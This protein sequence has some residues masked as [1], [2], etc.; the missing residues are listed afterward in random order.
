MNLEKISD[1]GKFP[2]DKKPVTKKEIEPGKFRK[3][4]EEVEQVNP[5][6]R[7]KRKLG[8]ESDAS[9]SS[10]ITSPASKPITQNTPSA[11]PP[12]DFYEE[13]SSVSESSSTEKTNKTSKKKDKTDKTK[14][15]LPAKELEQQEEDIEPISLSAVRK[16]SSSQPK[17]KAPSHNLENIPELSTEKKEALKRAHI[18]KDHRLAEKKAATEK[19]LQSEKNDSLPQEPAP[20]TKKP[21]TPSKTLA[22]S[23]QKFHPKKE[24]TQK[25][26]PP[27]KKHE[28]EAEELEIVLPTTHRTEAPAVAPTEALPPTLQNEEAARLFAHM[29]SQITAVVKKGET[30]TTITLTGEAFKN[31]V[32]FGSQIVIK[33]SPDLAARSYNI[34][35]F[36]ATSEAKTLFDKYAPTL[37]E[38]FQNKQ[39][40]FSIHRVES[41]HRSKLLIKRKPK[42]GDEESPGE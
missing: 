13:E 12:R 21:K 20:T 3:F 36:G 5:D 27:E 38:T 35:L 11:P 37:L 8:Q 32:F 34:E 26:Q 9:R 15:Q 17:K 41:S 42:A 28:K 6:E 2:H 16:K 33:E 14:Q 29:V 23:T 19:H 24:E 1:K 39:F 18:L 10:D 7:K 4:V 22:A 31:S 30:H 40:A 25:I